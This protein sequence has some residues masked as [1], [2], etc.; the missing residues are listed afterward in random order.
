MPVPTVV[1]FTEVPFFQT[2]KPKFYEEYCRK[3][4]DIARAIGLIPS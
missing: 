1:Y 2:Q 4:I 3:K